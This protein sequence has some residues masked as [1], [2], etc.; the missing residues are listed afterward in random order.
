[1]SVLGIDLARPTRLSRLLAR[2]TFRPWVRRRR[3]DVREL[4]LHLRRDLGIDD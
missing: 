4:S 1:M 2:L 3:T